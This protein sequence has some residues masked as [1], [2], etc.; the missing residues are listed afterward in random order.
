MPIWRGVTNDWGTASNWLADGSGS[1]VPDATKDAVFDSLSITPCTTGATARSCRDLITT[2]FTNVLTVGTSTTLGYIQVH[3]NITLGSQ[4][5]HLAGLSFIGIIGATCLLDVASGFTVPYLAFIYS[6]ISGTQTITLARS[7]VVTTLTKGGAAGN[8]ASI[9]AGSAMSIDLTNGTIISGTGSITLNANVTLKLFGTTTYGNVSVNGN[10]TSQVGST[11]NL[12][13]TFTHSGGTLNLSAGTVVPGTSTLTLATATISINMG[14]NSFYNIS[15]TATIATTVTMLSTINI[16]NNLLLSG[17]C[18]FNGA[19]D[20]IVGGNLS[21]S[22]G[23]L[24]NTT[25]GRKL[26]LTGTSTGVSTIT[27]HSSPTIQ[28]EID[29]VSNGFALTGA[30]GVVSL[31]YLATNVGSFTTTGSTLNYI[32]NLSINMNNS[33]NSWN[34]ITTTAL[35]RT[36]TLLSDLYC[37]QFGPTLSTDIINGVGYFICASGS[38][39]VMNTISGTAGLRFVGTSNSAW[40]Q[41]AGTSNSMRT[42]EFAKTAPGT[43]SIPNSFTY[44]GILK[45]V[46]GAVTHAGTLTLGTGS[47]VNTT[48]AVPWNNITIAAGATITI[49]SLFYIVGTLAITSGTTTFTG[50]AGWNCGTLT[51]SIASTTIVLQAG[52][53]YTTTTNVTMLGTNAGRITMRSNAPTATY[54]IWTLQNPATQSMVYVNAQGI[55]SNAGMTIYSFKGVVLTSLPALNWY[56]GASQGTKAFTFVS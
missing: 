7:F 32:N 40:N 39:G 35:F 2:G 14:S 47:T 16:A 30:L 11:I 15:Y 56:D 41:I 31:N 19:F 42:I 37:V 52:I 46:S 28:L 8:V 26:T 33:T 51:C 24:T 23:I 55:D 17:T 13:G 36:L 22:P 25:A 12:I 53:T 50:L 5:G 21:T 29:C 9:T 3:R 45:Y 43:V 4:P 6:V 49:S 34:I 27:S 1:G 38:T 18:N 48:S 44:S 20:I 10:V 54:A